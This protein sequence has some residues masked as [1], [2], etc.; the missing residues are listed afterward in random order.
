MKLKNKKTKNIDQIKLY[1]NLH[2][3]NLKQEWKKGYIEGFSTACD[4]IGDIIKL[5]K[6]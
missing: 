2:Q 4:I 5:Y 1:E 6:K 3:M